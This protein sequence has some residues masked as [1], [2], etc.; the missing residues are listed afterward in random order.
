MTGDIKFHTAIESPVVL[1]DIG[2]FESEIPVLKVF[3]K[4]L[5]SEVQTVF[6]NERSP[7]KSV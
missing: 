5:F 2:H 3:S 4:L 1:F 7:F 6:A